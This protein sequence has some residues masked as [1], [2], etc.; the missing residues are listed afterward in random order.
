MTDL[1]RKLAFAA[2]VGVAA[3]FWFEYYAQYYRWRACFNE[4]GRC[5]DSNGVVHMEQSQVVW[6]PLALLT[7]CIAF[8]QLWC[9]LRRPMPL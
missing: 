4:L 8:F 9:L 1:M 7:S 2:S 3:F 5:F 6:L